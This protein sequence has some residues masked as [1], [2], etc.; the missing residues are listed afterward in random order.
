MD[1]NLAL[2]LWNSNCSVLTEGI[3]G[4]VK[5]R[6]ERRRWDRIPLAVPLFVSA[7]DAEGKGFSDLTV[8]RDIGGGGL[9]F[10]THR[11]IPLRTKVAV[12]LPSTPWQKMLSRTRSSRI[13]KGRIIRVLPTESINYYAVEFTHPL[14]M[15]RSKATHPSRQPTG[16]TAGQTPTR[17]YTQSHPRHHP[18]G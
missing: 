12:Q 6:N 4:M 5:E 10:A 17:N 2:P 11:T 9:V 14:T 3:A 1:F 7:K 15:A 18:F 8:A 13:L 16:N